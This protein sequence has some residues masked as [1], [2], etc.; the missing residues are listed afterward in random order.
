VALAPQQVDTDDFSAALA[1]PE[2]R[3]RFVVADNEEALHELL[4][5]S[6]EEGR[7]F[8][9]P[10][11]RRLLE[12][13]E[14]GPVGGLG[15]AGTGKAGVA[16]HRAKWF[17]DHVATPGNEVLF[18]TFPRNRASDIQQNLS[19][20][21]NPAQRARIEVVNLEARVLSFLKKHGYDD[22]L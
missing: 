6:P 3:A 20:I 15:G 17:A 21:C 16:M 22:S 18:T 4:S 8:L 14:N 5:Q 7:V 2:S 10:A 1:R 13:K 9:H 19:K 12:G 11:P